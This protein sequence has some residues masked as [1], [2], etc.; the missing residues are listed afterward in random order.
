MFSGITFKP[1]LRPKLL[2]KKKRKV[3]H[4]NAANQKKKKLQKARRIK[5]YVIRNRDLAW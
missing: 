4:V 1:G 5:R 2:L 3:G